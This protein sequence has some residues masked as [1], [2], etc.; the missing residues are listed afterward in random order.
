M[1]ILDQGTGE[2]FTDPDPDHARAFFRTK[3][4]KLE[5]KLMT[6]KEAVEKFIPDG[7]YIASGGF[8]SNRISTAPLHEIVRQGKKNLGFSGHT[9]THDMQI[10]V[11][12]EC[13][14]R[15]D[16]AYIIGLEAR[17]LS[18]KARKYVEQGKLK[19]CEWTNA[20]LTWRY[21]AAAMG[22][23]FLPARNI[24]GTDTFKYSAGKITTCPY[25]GKKLVLY[26]AL[27]PDVAF[28]HVHRADIFGN[29][30]IDGISV[31]DADL[32]RAAKRVII[33]TEKIIDNSE[34]RRNPS[35]TIIPYFC[36]DAVCE[37]PFGAYPS[38]MPYEYFTDE[39][40]I[41]E[42]LTMEKDDEQYQSFIEKNILKTK[43]FHEY[44]Q[45]NGG[46]EKIAKL[47]AQEYMRE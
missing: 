37:V 24:M 12:G 29:C 30:H 26:P 28:I 9:A 41:K 23:P 44:L 13:I 15:C 39:A 34:I 6:V 1:E 16:V 46:I 33:T 19:L 36:V 27:Y 2:L 3:S 32:A 45:I 8:G 42:W 11:A 35:H 21:R 7:S 22:V 31:A 43:N 25:T 17:G 14:D 47:R 38:N 18:T 20:A 5:N 40:H 10:L 4:R